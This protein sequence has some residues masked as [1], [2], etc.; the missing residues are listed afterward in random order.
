MILA[1]SSIR[2]LESRTLKNK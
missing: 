1:P 2:G